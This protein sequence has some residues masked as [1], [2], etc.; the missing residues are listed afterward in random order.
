MTITKAFSEH[1]FVLFALILC[2]LR[3]F[4]V[5]AVKHKQHLASKNSADA[6]ASL[7]ALTNAQ[8][9]IGRIVWLI[10]DE[11]CKTPQ[12][13]QNVS[14][15]LGVNSDC[16]GAEN[17]A[18][19]GSSNLVTENQI[20]SAFEIIDT[21]G[22]GCLQLGDINEVLQV[23]VIE[24]DDGAEHDG[25]S[26]SI[27]RILRAVMSL[28][29]NGGAPSMSLAC[30]ELVCV[31]GCYL[32]DMSVAPVTL[33]RKHLQMGLTEIFTKHTY[34]DTVSG[35]IEASVATGAA[36]SHSSVVTEGSADWSARVSSAFAVQ[37]AREYLG[38]ATK[39]PGPSEGR[40]NRAGPTHQTLRC[41]LSWLNLLGDGVASA[42]D[43]EQERLPCP[44]AI[45][46]PLY[47]L[48]SRLAGAYGKVFLSYDVLINTRA[49]SV[50][51]AADGEV[52]PL[53][54]GVVL[55]FLRKELLSALLAGYDQLLVA[56]KAEQART[57][58]GSAAVSQMF[59]SIATQVLFDL[60]VVR[61]LYI[62]G[63]SGSAPEE[64]EVTARVEAWEE[65]VDSITYSLLEHECM[66]P[67]TRSYYNSVS[68]ALCPILHASA[69]AEL[70]AA[71]VGSGEGAA[72]AA[73]L[74]GHQDVLVGIFNKSSSSLGMFP[75]LS[76]PIATTSSSSSGAGGA[77]TS[78]GH[79]STN[80]KARISSLSGNRNDSSSG[81]VS[82]GS[83]MLTKAIGSFW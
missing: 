49:G 79:S 33:L 50:P 61:L 68:L 34:F 67:H 63:E 70:S 39:L 81:S 26:H 44:T 12:N 72:S 28:N 25:V 38:E 13:P 80:S 78:N 35:W 17:S 19:N 22:A 31:C 16:G 23:L 59:E 6:K 62:D 9:I 41:Q 53:C 71:P 32:T 65:H 8:L 73:P 36:V 57:A 30:S 77:G 66:G 37:L 1:L 2:I 7:D 56:F 45:S 10:N 51:T 82:S 83:S 3:N 52:G 15:L 58:T 40:G 69:S 64:Q 14:F 74:G 75:M 5:S 76:V 60:M 46:S 48:L 43:A 55:A 4:S 54:E 24:G 20:Y 27:S 11:L 42:G 47:L 21:D 18:S 29:N